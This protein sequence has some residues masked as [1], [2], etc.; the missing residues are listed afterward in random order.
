MATSQPIS[1]GSTKL[2]LL[3][4]IHNV[5]SLPPDG[6]DPSEIQEAAVIGAVSEMFGSFMDAFI[7]VDWSLSE[8]LAALS[9]YAHMSF[10]L[11]RLGGNN[12]RP[13]Q[14]YSD[15]HCTVKNAYFCMAKQQALDST[16][17][18]YL[19]W[20][21]DDRLEELFGIVRMIGGHDPNVLLLQ[22]LDRI[23]AALNV[24]AVY[25]CNPDLNPAGH[26]QLKV[27]SA[28][29]ADHLNPESRCG[30]AIVGDINLEATWC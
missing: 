1:T 25:S 9:K 21:G 8:Q 17:P 4:A 23:G 27:T 6:C 16:Q 20:V 19:F 2:N 11:F 22:L 7:R 12:V 30:N 29:K 15:T 13:H 18:F 14:L 26:Q 3:A 24:D 5:P 10:T 28:E